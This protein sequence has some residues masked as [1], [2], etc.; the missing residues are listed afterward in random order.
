MTAD[1][2][3][4][5]AFD[6]GHLFGP[7]TEPAAEIDCANRAKS[8]SN[9]D[10]CIRYSL[11]FLVHI[12]SLDGTKITPNDRFR[13][14]AAEFYSCFSAKYPCNVPCRKFAPPPAIRRSSCRSAVGE[15]HLRTQR[16]S[17]RS[18]GTF[19]D[20]LFS[21]SSTH[22]KSG[23]RPSVS[24]ISTAL[25]RQTC[26]QIRFRSLSTRAGYSE[27][28]NPA[29]EFAAGVSYRRKSL[30]PAPVH[31]PETLPV[32]FCCCREVVC[33]FR[34][35]PAGAN[36]QPFRQA[37]RNR[38]CSNCR[39][40]KWKK[41]STISSSRAQPSLLELPR[42][43][44][45]EQS[46]IATAGL[47]TRSVCDAFP[48]RKSVARECRTRSLPRRGKQ[49][50][51]AAGTCSGFTPD[52]HL[53]PRSAPCG[54]LREPLQ[55]KDNDFFR[56]TQPIPLFF[57]RKRRP[58]TT[59]SLLPAPRPAAIPPP[60]RALIRQFIGHCDGLARAAHR[61]HRRLPAAQPAAELGSQLLHLFGMFGSEVA[62]L[63][64]IGRQV[65]KFQFAGL[66]PV[67]EFPVPLRTAL[68]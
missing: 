59:G 17:N 18:R 14:A 36:S 23:E 20:K 33:D 22:E 35:L 16:P 68:R 45:E 31:S 48:T 65:V 64:Q 44:M 62:L 61:G 56:N 21:T 25:S 34:P 9:G 32:R 46:S 52:S 2:R 43:E 4:S 3:H 27:T 40:E 37:E 7:Q 60:R 12:V 1:D 5:P 55:S 39:G 47:L 8:A 67:D 26:W 6:T 42:R 13:T 57:D 11:R 24:L 29:A 66:H 15:R 53:I 30:R 54:G 51:T 28:K 63:A 19:A 49:E 50:H 10:A 38:V 41:N 58:P